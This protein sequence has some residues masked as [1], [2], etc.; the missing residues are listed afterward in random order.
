M[1]IEGIVFL[2]VKVK[3][4]SRED[5]GRPKE[6]ARENRVGFMKYHIRKGDGESRVEENGRD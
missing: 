4:E 2:E 5:L 1:N 3:M 6:S